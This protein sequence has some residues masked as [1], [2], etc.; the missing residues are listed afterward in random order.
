[1]LLIKR[2]PIYLE[3]LEMKNPSC[4]AGTGTRRIRLLQILQQWACV[5]IRGRVTNVIRGETASLVKRNFI[6]TYAQE[7]PDLIRQSRGKQVVD[8]DYAADLAA[9]TQSYSVY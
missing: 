3:K 8:A 1:M 5:Q 7:Y 9:G 4:L 2:P 6:R